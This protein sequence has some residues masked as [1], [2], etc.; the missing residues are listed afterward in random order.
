[1]LNVFDM[2]IEFGVALSKVV[3][4]VF[5]QPVDVA[6]AKGADAGGERGGVCWSVGDIRRY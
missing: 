6:K 5:G 3:K 2:F 1:M 4:I